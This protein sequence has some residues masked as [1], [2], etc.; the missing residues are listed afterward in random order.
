MKR[1]Y[2]VE[3]QKVT[4]PNRCKLLDLTLAKAGLG[5]PEGRLVIAEDGARW[6]AVSTWKRVHSMTLSTTNTLRATHGH[7]NDIISRRNSVSQ[8]LTILVDSIAD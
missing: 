5:Y 6:N 2:K 1:M 8:S 4:E 7:L 3:F